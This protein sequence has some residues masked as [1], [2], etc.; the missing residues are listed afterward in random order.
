VN[1]RGFTLHHIGVVFADPALRQGLLTASACGVH[2]AGVPD[3]LVAA[4][5]ADGEVR[6]PGKGALE[7]R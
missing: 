4:G 2:D 5:G 7:A 6:F 3:H 1:G